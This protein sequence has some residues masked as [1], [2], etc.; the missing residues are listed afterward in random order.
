MAKEVQTEGWMSVL[1]AFRRGEMAISH[2]SQGRA[3]FASE[4]YGSSGGTMGW[5]DG[6]RKE[7]LQERE[8]S[9]VFS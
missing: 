7:A 4:E 9:L 5:A 2:V 1:G 3:S 8:D 6:G